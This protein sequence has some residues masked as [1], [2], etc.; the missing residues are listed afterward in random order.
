MILPIRRFRSMN[1]DNSIKIAKPD[2][3]AHLA[4]WNVIHADKKNLADALKDYQEIKYA[5]A[6]REVEVMRLGRML[7]NEK[8][9]DKA[10]SSVCI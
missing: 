7:M 4:M 1:N 5:E 3:P 8:V 9:A 10:L 6:K 2:V